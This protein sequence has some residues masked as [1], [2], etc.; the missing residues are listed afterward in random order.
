[1]SD[2]PAGRTKSSSAPS[3]DSLTDRVLARVSDAGRAMDRRDRAS[4]PKSRRRDPAPPDPRAASATR[5]PAQVREARSLRRVFHDLGVSYRKYRRQTGA[6]VSSDVRE[7]AYRFRR[8]LNIASLIL[9]AASLD[10]LE[11]LPW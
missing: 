7:A 2:L 11:I 6:P 1:M 9:V 8:E 3:P 5:T 10:E 4:R